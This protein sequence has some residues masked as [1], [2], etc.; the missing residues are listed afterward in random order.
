VWLSLKKG[1][2]MRNTTRGLFDEQFRLEKISKQNDPLEK[3][4]AHID[5]EFFRKP[6]E[7]ILERIKRKGIIK[8]G[9]R[10]MTT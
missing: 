1:K 4:L 7:D 5:F 10:P 8:V 3:L 2:Y 6:L 9:A